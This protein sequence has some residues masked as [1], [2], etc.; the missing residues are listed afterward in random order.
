MTFSSFRETSKP[1]FKVLKIMNIYEI[2]LYL[3]TN[4]I[5][6]HCYGKLQEPIRLLTRIIQGH[7]KKYTLILKEQVMENF[8]F[9][10]EEQ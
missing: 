7:L 10:M 3:I 6:L 4:F 5:C 2:N 1:L 9:N 8:L